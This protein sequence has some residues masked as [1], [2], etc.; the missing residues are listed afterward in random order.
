MAFHG[1]SRDNKKKH[2]LYAIHDKEEKDVF[3]YGISDSTIEKDG[4]SR[5]MRQQVDFLNR[6]AGWVRFF[7][8]VLIRGIIGRK[9]ARKIEDEHVDAYR[10][11]HGRNPRGNVIK[12]KG[13][14]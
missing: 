11:K 12:T 4:Y 8:V 5:R 10:E 1:N 13:Q 2:H 9:E 3:K 6:A 14:K 7:A